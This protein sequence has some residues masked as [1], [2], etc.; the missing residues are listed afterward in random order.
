MCFT[1]YYKENMISLFCI[2]IRNLIIVLCTCTNLHSSIINFHFKIIQKFKKL[3]L[4]QSIYHCVIFIR[5]IVE[6]IH[7]SLSLMTQQLLSANDAL[8]MIEKGQKAMISVTSKADRGT[9]VF[10]LL[11]R[12]EK[13]T[14]ADP[15]LAV[16]IFHP[17]VRN[18]RE[19][20]S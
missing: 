10:R 11:R 17:S 2:N 3:K 18:Y 12:N 8:P 4:Y 16:S 13:K 5:E 9:I 6:G 20:G 15:L 7:I 19:G 1:Q 14:C